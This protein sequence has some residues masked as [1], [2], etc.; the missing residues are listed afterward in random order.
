MTVQTE[1][2]RRLAELK[3]R[4]FGIFADCRN[5]TEMLHPTWRVDHSLHRLQATRKLIR[6]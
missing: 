6:D 4:E 1:R 2:E 3:Q 5:R